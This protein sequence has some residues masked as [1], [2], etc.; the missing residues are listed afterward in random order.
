MKINFNIHSAAAWGTLSAAVVTFVISVLSAFGIV[1]KQTD[2]TTIYGAVTA[3]IS[4][5]TTLGILVA[6]TDKQYEPKH[7][8]SDKDGE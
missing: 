2:A 8:K 5:L 7:E 1:V 3:V 6:P 4:A